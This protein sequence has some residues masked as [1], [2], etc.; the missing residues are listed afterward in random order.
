AFGVWHQPASPFELKLVGELQHFFLGTFAAMKQN[1]G[2]FR[3]FARTSCL[4]QPKW[5]RG[6]SVCHSKWVCL[7]TPVIAASRIPRRGA[8][9]RDPSTVQLTVPRALVPQ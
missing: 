9:A 6:D 8:M 1:P 4:A 5:R 3:G 2:P 7:P